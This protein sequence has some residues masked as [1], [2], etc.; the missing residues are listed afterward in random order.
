VGGGGG[1]V[2]GGGALSYIGSHPQYFL[3]LPSFTFPSF[4]GIISH[5]IQD[6][7]VLILK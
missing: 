5:T 2:V 4:Y 6:L 7:L 3:F 1:G